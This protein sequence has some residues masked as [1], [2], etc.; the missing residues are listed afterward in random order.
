M[1]DPQSEYRK[2]F[3]MVGTSQEPFLVA[4]PPYK[5]SGCLVR[6]RQRLPQLGEHT[7]EVLSEVLGGRRE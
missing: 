2:S 3:E 7:E 6:A 4:N 5:L 1:A